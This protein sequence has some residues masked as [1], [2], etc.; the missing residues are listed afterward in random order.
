MWVCD[1]TKIA[2]MHF[3][4]DRQSIYHYLLNVGLFVAGFFS[5]TTGSGV[6]FFCGLPAPNRENV[7][8]FVAGF[9]STTG[10]GAVFCALLA[11]ASAAAAFLFCVNST[12]YQT[13]ICI[14]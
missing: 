2:H 14:S 6:A 5:T 3:I 11:A 9:F 4:E 12:S 13:S 10:A 1:R 7:G 8:L